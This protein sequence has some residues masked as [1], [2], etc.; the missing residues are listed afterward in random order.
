METTNN[1]NIK[2]IRLHGGEDIIANFI[3]SEDKETAILHDPMQ[4]IF[5]RIPTTGQTVMMMMPW[6]PIEIIE[7]NQAVLYTSD[8]LTIIDPK[9]SAIQHY[10]EVV[11]EAQKRMD[12]VDFITESEDG[13][14][15][16]GEDDDEETSETK[17]FNVDE[18]LELIKEKKNKRL[19]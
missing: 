3:E 8:I 1:N 14:E 9:E 18:L 10:G 12:E 6:L 19:H 16:D 11:M 13:D 4:V 2:I 17:D 5:K 15:K 7:N